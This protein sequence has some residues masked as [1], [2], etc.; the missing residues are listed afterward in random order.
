MEGAVAKL[1][2]SRK[3]VFQKRLL[4]K[5][6]NNCVDLENFVASIVLLVSS[7]TMNQQSTN[8][9]LA[10]SNE[11]PNNETRRVHLMCIGVILS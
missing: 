10:K 11:M 4:V 1:C 2:V 7:K 6:V 9:L 3:M 5:F 8:T